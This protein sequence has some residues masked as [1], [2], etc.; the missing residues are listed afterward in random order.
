MRLNN[1]TIGILVWLAVMLIGTLGAFRDNGRL[2]D[3]GSPARN[4]LRRPP[5]LPATTAV[6]P[7]PSPSDPSF[8]VETSPQGNSSGTAFALGGER[9]MT[10]RHVVDGCDST[11]LLTSPRRGIRAGAVA[12]H[13]GADLA[14]IRVP[15]SAPPVRISG[16]PLYIGQDGYHFGYPRGEPG[17]VRSQLIGRRVM[18][19]GRRGKAEPV[20]AWAEVE[21]MPDGDTPLSGMS[22]GPVFNAA[23]QLI[24]VSVAASV[25]RGRIMTATPATIQDMLERAVVTPA[26]DGVSPRLAPATFATAGDQLR[27]DRTVSKVICIV[28]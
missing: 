16:T 22:G 8:T 26:T 9:W 13:P 6:L 2:V 18:R 15:L 5:P 21:R 7:A 20:I 12:L 24:G 17:A 4:S 25:R 1:G 11:G 14:I 3:A 19:S 27:S 10:A 28:N 23:G